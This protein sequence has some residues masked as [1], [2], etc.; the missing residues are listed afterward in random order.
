MPNELTPNLV[1]AALGIFLVGL[2]V[3]SRVFSTPP[4]I[5]ISGAKVLVPLLYFAFFFDGS[6]TLVDDW[7]YFENGQDLLKEGYDPFTILFDGESLLYLLAMSAGHH[8]LYNWYNLFAQW[9]FGEYYY[10][11]V[12]LNVG[13]T[14]GAGL[15]LYRLALVSKFPKSYAR[16]L[17]LFFLLHWELLAWSSVVN[18]K[19]TLVLLM[20]VALMYAGMRL[21]QT[22]KIVYAVSVVG[23]VFLFYWIRFYV[24]FTLLLSALL[25]LLLLR[26]GNGRVGLIIIVGGMVAG[27]SYFVGWGEVHEGFGTLN[28]GFGAL[29]GAAKMMITPRPWAISTD[30]SFLLLPSILNWMFFFP[31]LVGTTMLWRDAPHLRAMLIYLLAAL[32]FYGA[33]EELLGPR[34]RFQLLFIYAWAQFHFAWYLL[35]TGRQKYSA[36]QGIA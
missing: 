7:I 36:L 28:V 27:Y 16:G 1:V 19:D 2:A 18:L 21:A 25:Y 3:C 31:T 22:R 33:F 24:P 26:G 14:F 12:F 17:F 10:S 30:Y 5:L 15:L 13:L 29:A 8:V 4:A 34:Q 9:L 23:L 35:R 20:T 11:A 6:W 32:L